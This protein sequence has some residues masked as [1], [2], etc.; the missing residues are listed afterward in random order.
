MLVGVQ[1]LG[2]AIPVGL[3]YIVLD[4][5]GFDAKLGAANTP[6]AIDGL[7]LLFL[8]PPIIAALI[9]AWLAKGWTIDRDEQ[10]RIIT[11]LEGKR[12]S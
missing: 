10:Q 7:V 1:K 2:Y 5:I 4:A 3:A 9:A 11:E 8:L 12:A 6:D